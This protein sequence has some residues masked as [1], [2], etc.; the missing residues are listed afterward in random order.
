MNTFPN[1]VFSKYHADDPSLSLHFSSFP[2]YMF[3]WFC[4]ST[5]RYIFHF[6]ICISFEYL[7]KMCLNMIFHFWIL[8]NIL[9][10]MIMLFLARHSNEKQIQACLEPLP[11]PCQ[12]NQIVWVLFGR[13]WSKSGFWLSIILRRSQCHYPRELYISTKLNWNLLWNHHPF[14][15]HLYSCFHSCSRLHVVCFQ[16]PFLHSICGKF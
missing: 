10:W 2:V 1:N 8:L 13:F 14:L 6:L 16:S 12:R 5:V 9:P 11:V 7:W 3:C 15:R 4:L